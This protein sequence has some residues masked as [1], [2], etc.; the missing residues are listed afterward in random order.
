MIKDRLAEALLGAAAEAQSRGKLINVALPEVAVE[1]TQRPEHG[2]YASSLPLKLARGMGMSPM[3]IA[4]RL[5]ESLP[6]MP[7]IEKVTIAPPG[8]INFKLSASWLAS[9]VDV[10]LQAGHEYA[11]SNLGRQAKVQ[12]EFV[13]V[14]PT[15]PLHV[16]HGRGAVL[17]SALANVLGTCGYVVEKE[18]YVNDAGSQIE[19]FHRSLYARYQQYFGLSAEMP[20]NGYM[21]AY[22]IELAAEMARE[23][24]H[25]FLDVP[26]EA[27]VKEL[28]EIGIVR[29]L[30]QISVD[31]AL[32]GVSFDSWFREKTLFETGLYKKV[33]QL[34]AD[35]GF[36]AKKEGATWFVSTALGE[37]KDNVL[38][39]SDGS[40]TYFASDIAYHFDKFVQRGFAKVIDIW[41]ADHQ[42]HVSRIKAAASALGIDPERLTVI[43]TQMV[44]LRRGEELVK[45]SKRSG[46]LITLKELIDEVGADACRFFFLS[47]SADAQM[48]FDIELAKKQSADNPVYYVQYAH[49]RIASILSFAEEKGISYGEGDVSLLTA[50]KELA[51]VRKMLLLPEVLETVSQTLEPHHLTYYAT[52]LATAFHDFYTDCRVVSS[53]ERMTGARLKLVKSAK[54]ALARVLKL[55]GMTAPEHM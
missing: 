21:G 10:I 53:D 16:G 51:L 52:D 36:V 2:D 33:M 3:E 50:S 29:M 26:A 12:L 41:G 37:S 23:Y 45:V 30:G 14:N 13:S 20:A 46:E 11:R 7:E 15:G 40:P 35:R 55:M 8:F 44:A 39:R 48:D 6:P 28:G 18:Y 31:L 43:I 19:A 25:K 22:M 42:G 4:K 32:V 24:G 9:Q 47:R 5:I 17:G 1:R 49:A 38:V 27:A 54:V 34:L